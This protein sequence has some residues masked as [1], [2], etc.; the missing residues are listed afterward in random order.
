M[1]FEKRYFNTDRSIYIPIS[2]LGFHNYIYIR[3]INAVHGSEPISIPKEK[4]LIQKV[5]IQKLV[6]YI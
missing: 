2:A 5:V 3:I 4:D 1:S 6:V